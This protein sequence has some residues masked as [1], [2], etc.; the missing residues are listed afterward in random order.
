MQNVD[1]MVFLKMGGVTNLRLNHNELKEPLA[2]T[3][4]GF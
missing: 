1:L 4:G 2:D 3:M